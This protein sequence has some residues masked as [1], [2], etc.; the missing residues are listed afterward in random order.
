MATVTSKCP[1]C[2]AQITFDSK[3]KLVTCEY[4]ASK[5]E[6]TGK[7]GAE[8]EVFNLVL[9]NTSDFIKK[10]IVTARE[11]LGKYWESPEYDITTNTAR[12]SDGI[13]GT[14][15]LTDDAL[16]FTPSRVIN[17]F[18]NHATKTIVNISD[19]CGYKKFS[20]D[21]YDR[22]ILFFYKA[23]EEIKK[24]MFSIFGFDI[25]RDKFL[26]NVEYFRK[27]YF[28]KRRLPIPDLMEESD[29]VIAKV[30]VN[31]WISIWPILTIAFKI[32]LV[33]I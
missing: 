13:T 28:F 29:G 32:I 1:H 6:I 31:M 18:N 3:D 33:I 2:G 7:Q 25:T 12:L 16:I 27:Q 5:I 11:F 30:P 20:I 23:D 24:I 9:K 4:C 17:M 8:G 14:V 21:E 22:G 19:I 10:N 26:N 15:K